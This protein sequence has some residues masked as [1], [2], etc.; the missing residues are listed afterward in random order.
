MI[1]VVPILIVLAGVTGGQRPAESAAALI[2]RA[3]DAAQQGRRAEAKGLLKSAADAHHSVRAMLELARLQA[4]EGDRTGAMATLRAARALAPNSE[5]VLSAFAELSLAADMTVP[6]IL[7]LESLT[8]LYPDVARYSYLL[9]VGLMGAGAAPAAIAA[10]ERANAL[11]ADRPLTLIALGLACNNQKQYD[12][13][14]T[15]LQRALVLD[16]DRVEA[17]AALA[18]A[19]A[20]L[21]DLEAA[22]RDASRVIARAPADA[23]ANLVIGTVRMTQ[24]R[25]ADARDAFIIAA[26]TDARSPKPE[27][28]L[29]LAYARLGDEA[30]AQRHVELYQQKLRAM[31]DAIKALHGA[32]GSGR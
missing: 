16:P 25:Y 7:T 27:Y 2:A 3:T 28:Q 17:L 14:R 13:A 5:E 9:G 12:R 11:D 29:S 4:G 18:E 22:E 21:G 32:G 31:E 10:L 24:Q 15:L 8:R 30:S 19:E 20:G 26:T 1:I 6:A 23:T